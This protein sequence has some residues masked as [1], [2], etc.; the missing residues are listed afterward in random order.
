[1]LLTNDA[2]PPPAFVPPSPPQTGSDGSYI[3]RNPDPSSGRSVLVEPDGRILNIKDGGMF[4][5]LA[6]TRGVVDVAGQEPLTKHTNGDATCSSSGA[7]P[8][9]F[10]PLGVGNGNIPD[11]VILREDVRGLPSGSIQHTWLVNSSGKL[12][13]IPDGGTY[14]CLAYRNAVIWNVPLAAAQ[15]WPDDRIDGTPASCG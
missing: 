6:A 10:M 12:Q 7:A 5:C 1:V 2:P 14:L 3:A 9:N 4:L 8:W 13:S 11:N 15:A